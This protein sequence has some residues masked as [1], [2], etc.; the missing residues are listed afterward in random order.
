MRHL[1]QIVASQMMARHG[2]ASELARYHVETMD[3]EELWWRFRYYRAHAGMELS[4][5]G[6]TNQ[7]RSPSLLPCFDARDDDG[8]LAALYCVPEKEIHAAH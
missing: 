7:L 5:A 3:A 4:V 2:I 1:R 8:R 6:P